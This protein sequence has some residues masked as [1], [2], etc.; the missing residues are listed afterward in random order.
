[1]AKSNAEAIDLLEE[2]R[3]A[4]DERSYTIEAPESESG[5]K[6]G[7][8][9]FYGGSGTAFCLGT[10]LWAAVNSRLETITDGRMARVLQRQDRDLAALERLKA[11]E[12]GSEQ[13][14]RLTGRGFFHEDEWVVALARPESPSVAGGGDTLADATDAA[15]AKLEAARPKVCECCGQAVKPEGTE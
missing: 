11:W 3:A 6:W 12:D 14:F 13:W 4:D 8:E 5:G 1:M 10:S 2:W 9:L 7:I 15:F